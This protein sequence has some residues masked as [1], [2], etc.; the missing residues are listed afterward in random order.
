MFDSVI[1]KKGFA[2]GLVGALQAVLPTIFAI[3]GLYVVQR[4][5]R[6]SID[7]PFLVLLMTVAVLSFGLLESRQELTARLSSSRGAVS[8]AI[9][10]RWLVL[11]SVLFAVGYITK[12]SAIYSRRVI[13]TWA[14]VTPCAL[15]LVSMA[16]LEVLR[17]LMSDPANMRRV[18][19]AGCNDIS[20]T[21][22]E[23]LQKNPELCMSVV[24]FF[25][26][27]SLERLGTKIS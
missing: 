10:L 11:L 7:D 3:G 26:D 12:S 22:A 14:A 8:I 6:I 4:A 17:R 2:I 16:L 20:A 5:Y 13:L 27:R 24:G 25:D 18:I 9:L 19:F 15:I 1:F 21:L 23:R